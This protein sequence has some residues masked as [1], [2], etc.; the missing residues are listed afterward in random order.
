MKPGD[1]DAEFFENYTEEQLD[2]VSTNSDE[3]AMLSESRYGTF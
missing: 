1:T 3:I 2:F